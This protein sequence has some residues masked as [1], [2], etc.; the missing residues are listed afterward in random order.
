MMEILETVLW[1]IATPIMLFV[2]LAWLGFIFGLMSDPYYGIKNL[3]G[4][5]R[6]KLMKLLKRYENVRFRRK[7]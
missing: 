2:G 7:Q 5:P 3:K 1:I 6:Q 4:K